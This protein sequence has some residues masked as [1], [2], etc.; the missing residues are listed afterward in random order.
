MSYTKCFYASGSR[1]FMHHPNGSGADRVINVSTRIYVNLILTPSKCGFYTDLN[2]YFCI[3]R[4]KRI[5]HTRLALTA[6]R[7]FARSFSAVI[8]FHNKYVELKALYRKNM[9]NSLDFIFISVK[10]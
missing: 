4:F 7:I 2:E 5:I 9:K 3:F 6:Y 1:F 10:Q 8:T